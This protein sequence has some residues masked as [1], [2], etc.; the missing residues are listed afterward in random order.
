[1]LSGQTAGA[2]KEGVIK[3]IDVLWITAG[4]GCECL[5]TRLSELC[6]PSAV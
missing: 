5:A 3:E 4:L 1:M 2:I 6:A